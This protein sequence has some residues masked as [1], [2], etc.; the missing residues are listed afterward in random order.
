MAEE[1]NKQTLAENTD[2]NDIQAFDQEFDRQSDAMRDAIR[3][4]MLANVDKEIADP[5]KREAMK[6]QMQQNWAEV[7]ALDK[8]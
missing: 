3:K 2:Q 5:E 1:T 7:D 6:R 4:E 8:S